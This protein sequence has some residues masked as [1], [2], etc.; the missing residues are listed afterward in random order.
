MPSLFE[1]YRPSCWDDVVGQDKAV[2]RCQ[3]LIAGGLGGR[4]VWISGPSG[5]GKSTIA[6]LLASSIADEFSTEEID[7]QDLTPARLGEWERELHCRAMTGP[8]GRAVI[9]NEAHGISKAAILKL[10]VILER[11][12]AH[13]VWIFTTTCDGQDTL[14]DNCQDAGPFLSRCLPIE[15]ARRG[16]ADAFAERART[17]AQA[18]GL[19]GKPIEAYKR[20]A[21]DCRNNLR[22]MLT[23]IE[24]G[25]ML[26]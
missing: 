15:L 18:E 6:R 2:S 14:F 22:M 4:A 20:L 10:L 11:I 12:P 13:V 26:D 3:R 7:A 17:I 1:K 25:A 23:R 5:A 24:S 21:Q 16:L 9:V 19:D 8:G